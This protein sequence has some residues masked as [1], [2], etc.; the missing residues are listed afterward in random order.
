LKR[1]WLQQSGKRSVLAGYNYQRMSASTL[2]LSEP[3][4]VDGI[5]P[6]G[7]QSTVTG[8]YIFYI[9]CMICNF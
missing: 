3:L 2:V 9:I 7:T 6:A 4:D 8:I 5:T 1:V